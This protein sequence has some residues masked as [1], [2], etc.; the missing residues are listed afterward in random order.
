M[1]LIGVRLLA[2]AALPVLGGC[3]TA[4]MEASPVT[5]ATE[6][7]GQVVPVEP[8][9]PTWAA[10]DPE[11]DR[12]IDALMARMTIEDKVGQLT[13]LTSDWESTGP[14]MRDTYKQDIRSGRVGAIFNAYTSA[15][16]RELQRLAVEETRLGIPLLFGY[17]VIHGHRTIFP[18]SLGEAA[19]WDMT[20]VEKAARVSALEASAEGLHWTF[21][22]MVDIAR[23]ARW[24]RI[25]EGAGEDVYLGSQ[26]ARARVRGYQGDDLGATD[27]ILATAKHFAGYGAA[28]AG[29][30][31]HTVDISERTLRDVYLPPFE[32]AVD[33]GVATFMTAFNEY[34]GVPASGSRYLL[35]DVLRDQWGFDGFVVTDYTSINEMVPHGYAKDLKQAGE[36]ALD[37]GVDMDMQGA[38]FMDHLAQS[39]ADGKVEMAAVDR[40]VRRILEMKYR[41]G[42]FE[43]P[44]RY[45]DEAR[46]KAT[47]YK[48]EFLEAARD[49][50]RK[51]MVLLKNEGN[52]LP[53][54]A[55]AKRIA[56]IGPLGN[57]KPDMIGSWA[58]AGDR[59]TRPVTVLEGM[60]ANAR[61]GVS[62]E[63][64]KGASYEFADEGKTD[65]FAEALALAERS[66][67]IV[68][69]MGEK[70]DMTGEAASRTSLDLP[71]N[72]QA[73]LEKLVA[74][75]K[76]VVLVLMSGRPNSVTWANDNVPAIL[77]AWYPGT[78]GGHAVA[79]VVYGDYNPSGKL[80]VTF[81]RTVGQ[82]PIHYDMKNTGRPIEL[83]EPGAKYV[84]R[85]LNT[86]NDP[87]Y[88]FG[89]GLSY[90]SFAYSPATLSAPTMGA[91]GSI[92]AS[93]TITNTGDVAGEEVV[94]LYVR[95]LVG[96]VTRPVQELKG[97]EKIALQPGES[98]TVSFTLKPADL[99]FTRGDMSHGWEPGEFRLWIAPSSGAEAATPV[100]FRLTE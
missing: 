82:V 9:E 50:A 63:Y 78:Q 98:R 90:T 99:A 56:V 46:E 36:Q 20:A 100:T 74:T 48:P 42:L 51:S 7:R 11:M 68:A 47:L 2:L 67:V 16:T 76:P 77:H 25:S 8:A 27:T 64:A 3:A 94:Q 12:T 30:D 1:T 71:G 32:A 92:T 10:P 39:V 14:T 5:A 66:D 69:T 91:G 17:D 62:V 55:S 53:L 45:A 81:P 97:F 87:L 37:A 88:R 57:S 60:Q 75:G 43:D 21:S 80:P 29:R 49:V 44:Y 19:S 73:L 65:G 15:Y 83:G 54:A 95:D 72:Q 70:W 84:S 34:D 96:S 59:G 6:A 79:D 61:D 52:A 26:V 33:E 85:Y 4:A 40:A 86:S 13:L 23:D 93:A 89:Y 58:A 18:I 41:L 38:V 35:T 24:G 31:Y 22:P 28:Q